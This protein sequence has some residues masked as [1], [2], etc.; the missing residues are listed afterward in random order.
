MYALYIYYTYTYI[1]FICICISTNPNHQMYTLP[2]AR[3]LRRT[4]THLRLYGKA[5]LQRIPSEQLTLS[6]LQWGHDRS[7]VD[8]RDSYS[9]SCSSITAPCITSNRSSSQRETLPSIYL[10]PWSSRFFSFFFFLGRSLS[11]A[12][13]EIGW[14]A[15][16]VVVR[17]T[18]L[19]AQTV[20]ATKTFA[21]DLPHFVASLQTALLQFL[22]RAFLQHLLETKIAV[23]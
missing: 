6:S 20:L 1:C 3:T 15:F 16:P 14:L 9:D 7:T 10:S 2:L 11:T 13:P 12:W 4:R 22:S 5:S 8:S 18:I 23:Q 21:R 17:P 19:N